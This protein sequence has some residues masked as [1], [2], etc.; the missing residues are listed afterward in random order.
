MISVLLADDHQMFLDGVK[1]FLKNEPK[2]T[3]VGEALNG[4]QVLEIMQDTAVDI[5]IL[6]IRMP[7]M[8][9][10]ATI[11][12]L[13]KRH[14]ETK[15]LVLT[16]DQDPDLILKFLHYQAN[17]FLLKDR[18]KEEL[19]SAI[20]AIHNN[21]TYYPPSIMKGII[22]IPYT[23]EPDIKFTER[24]IEVLQLIAKGFRDKEIGE[25]LFIRNLT[26]QTHCRNMRKKAGVNNRIE[27]INYGKEKGL[28]K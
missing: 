24:E 25:K 23:P 15:V 11:K 20:Y 8:D 10:E 9:G 19:I 6:D 27:L 14:P 17:G 1:S 3:V 12:E 5:V 2:I 16:Y 21:N 26:V 28:I 18:S 13:R 4:K 22:D 7:E